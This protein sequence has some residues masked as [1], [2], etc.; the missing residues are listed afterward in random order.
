MRLH[1]FL[2]AILLSTLL[3]ACGGTLSTGEDTETDPSTT[4][5]GTTDPAV[6]TISTS[7]LS[8]PD[9]WDDE[10]DDVDECSE[11]TEVSVVQPGI[12]AVTL[13]QDGTALAREIVDGELTKGTLSPDSALTNT[14]GIAFFT[15]TANNEEGAS[16]ATLSST[17]TIDEVEQTATTTH[18]FSIGYSSFALAI[19]ND[20][21]GESIAQNST[22]LITV[23]LTSDGDLYTTPVTISFNS[24]CAT[25]GTASL[26][27][28]ITT[29]GGIAQATYQPIGCVGDDVITATESSGEFAS[30][31]INVDSSPADSIQFISATPTSI[32]VQ[33]TGGADRQETSTILFKIVD[34]NGYA[35]SLQDVEFELERAPSGATISP[36]LGTTNSD[37]EVYTVVSAGAGSGTLKVKVKLPE[38]DPIISSVSSEL[39]VSTGLPDQNSFSVSLENHSPEVLEFDGVKVAVSV[40]LADHHNNAVPDGT[41]VFFHAEAGAINDEAS[42]TIGSCTTTGSACSVNWVSGGDEPAGNKL[43]NQGLTYGCAA[44]SIYS[45]APCINA[46]GMGQPYGGRVTITAFAEG[47]ETF[48]DNDYDGVFT[49]GETFTDDNCDG[50][51][52]YN[53]S[54]VDADGN[55]E[56]TYADTYTDSD[57]SGTYN[58]VETFVD[59][60]NDGEY[61]YAETFTDANGDGVYN[62]ADTYTDSDENGEYTYAETYIDSNDDGEYTY[63]EEFLDRDNDGEFDAVAEDFVDSDGNGEYTAEEKFTDK[64]NDG[65]T[66]PEA[67]T[68]VNQIAYLDHL[69]NEI[70]YNEKPDG[71]YTSDEPYNDK[72]GDGEYSGSEPYID[73]NNNGIY[74]EGYILADGTIYPAEI[75]VDRNKN[76]VRDTY[77]GDDEPYTDT[78]GNNIFDIGETF[79]DADKNGVYSTGDAYEDANGD[80]YFTL[81]ESYTDSDGNK[82]YSYAEIFTDTNDNGS[83]DIAEAYTDSNKDGLYTPDESYIDNNNDGEYTSEGEAFVDTNENGVFDEF[84][85][86]FTDTN[87]D[88]KY[89]ATAEAYADDNGDGEYT[90]AESFTDLDGNGEYTVRDTFEDANGDE[91]YTGDTFQDLPEVFYDFNEDGLFKANRF[92]LNGVCN[93]AVDLQDDPSIAGAQDEDIQDRD[94]DGFTFGNLLFNGLTCSENE[95]AEGHCEPEMVHV[96]DNITLIMASK[97]QYIR[98]MHNGTE[99]NTV[100][101]TTSTG[102]G[103]VGLNVYIADI[104]NN[105]PPTDTEI[106]IATA[107]GVLSS[108]A[109]FI[110]PS[111][112]AV[113]PYY[114]PIILTRETDGNDADFGALSITITTPSEISKT[115]NVYVYDDG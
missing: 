89:T 25:E 105:R 111:S 102:Q 32:A 11:I 39:S 28:E 15:V 8:C 65:Y 1:H 84:S 43:N 98:V 30:T 83:Y 94:G 96:R 97:N 67:Y 5:P 95:A 31:T 3:T 106:T 55:G 9:D 34:E 60:N 4:D 78:N 35:S 109:S 114:L 115:Y 48:T 53:E 6:V 14:Q 44:S 107:N 71:H 99:T 52:T 2:Y 75:F 110:V 81:A 40:Q 22:A 10:T 87:G 108:D 112:N 104:Y 20:T 21:D 80:G 77:D 79:A 93:V 45:F 62:E 12:L 91:K 18:N 27:T 74:D 51:Y 66:S 33:G 85:E 64:D 23:T 63:A 24:A 7:L 72:N 54:Y 37:G 17:V 92:N 69:E 59:A 73:I 41:T 49:H 90:Y 68:D 46:E 113:G 76:G 88:S 100:D 16:K 70:V 13:K 61:T 36:I 38:S 103:T 57:N 19:E 56:Y 82:E 50:T 58:S 26:D 101:L 86:S 42:G 47:E 29:V